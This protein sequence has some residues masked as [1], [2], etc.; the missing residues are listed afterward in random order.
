MSGSLALWALIA[1][2]APDAGVL[3]GG[4]PA[5][6]APVD[7]GA[8]AA[9][10]T[11]PPAKGPP[12]EVTLDCA[13]DPIR[14]GEALVCTLTALHPPDVSITVTA[15]PAFAPDD[16]LPAT[17]RPD[18]RLET[19]R[20]FTLRPDS[21]RKVR[22]DGLAVIWQES[23]GGEGRLTLP[24]KI[25]NTRSVLGG[26]PDPTFRDFDNPGEAGPDP[27]WNAH[28]P[29]P[30]RVFNW[31][32]F[33]ALCVL[34]ATALGVG[35]GVAIKRWL[36]ARRPDPGPPV[37][38][39]PAHVIAFEALDRLAA[40][41]LPGQGRVGDYYVRLSE[42][43]RAYL[44]R[45]FG[46]DAPEMTSNQIRTWAERAPITTEARLGLDDFLTETDLV[47]FAD[48]NPT[49]S[50]LDTVTRLGRGLISLTRAADPT[51]GKPSDAPPAPEDPA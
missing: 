17:P 1:L 7:A 31:P 10:D 43:I 6:A 42:I 9:P 2:F 37:D 26:V 32:L 51:P 30:W 39:R 19:I 24:R 4:E 41:D 28:G 22:V 8:P 20:R 47:K 44:D 33:I 25:I 46:I 15:P 34:G 50:E 40:E 27:F 35:I 5:A 12:P 21:L 23:T 3:A 29:L 36:D 38:P 18:G 14:I 45:R 13:P 11:P 49:P 16:P 48:L